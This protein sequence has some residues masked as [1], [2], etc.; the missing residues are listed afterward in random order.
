MP[1]NGRTT[2]KL[3]SKGGKESLFLPDRPHTPYR[4]GGFSI[5]CDRKGQ[6]YRE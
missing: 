6:F 2:G 3:R 4:G 1:G 5:A